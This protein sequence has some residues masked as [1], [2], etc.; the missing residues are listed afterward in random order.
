MLEVKCEVGFEGPI[1]DVLEPLHNKA[2]AIL[3]NKSQ[4]YSRPFQ[5][6]QHQEPPEMRIGKES[7]TVK[8]DP[9]REVV[10][11]GSRQQCKDAGSRPFVLYIMH[12][13]V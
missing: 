9:F 13:A 1:R 7:N 4:P 12:L 8:V 5:R 2:R 10:T 6:F 11:R 3:A